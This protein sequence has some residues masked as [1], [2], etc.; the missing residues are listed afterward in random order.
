MEKS[1]GLA[2]IAILNSQNEPI[3]TRSFGGVNEADMQFSAYASLDI[4]QEKVV[5]SQRSDEVSE[6]FMGFISPTLVGVN[7][8][9]IYAYMGATGFK[10]VAVIDESDMPPSKVK[11]LFENVS[12][13]Y[14]DLICNPLLVKIDSPSFVSRIDELAKAF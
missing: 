12:K 8:Y 7:L 11:E 3:F 2:F 13:L 10:I 1:H 6:P 14:V 5:A 4:L 9:K